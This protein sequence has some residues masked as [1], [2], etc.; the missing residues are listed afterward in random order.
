MTEKFERYSDVLNRLASEAIE[1][2]PEQW[3]E[4]VL[5]ISCDGAGINY[6]LKNPNSDLRASISED[7]RSLCE[8]LYVVM[9]NAGEVWV[10]ANVKF[11][12]KEDAEWGFS[13]EFSYS[14][15]N[16]NQQSTTTQKTK[17]ANA[18]TTWQTKLTPPPKWA[19]SPEKLL[20]EFMRDY[21]V[22]NDQSHQ[23]SE[24][25]EFSES[26]M[27]SIEA[28]WKK[29]TDKYCR[30]GFQGEPI[31]F[32]SESL[33]DTSRETIIS[34][35]INANVAIAKTESKNSHIA[36]YSDNYEYALSYD[37][38]RWFLEQI[39]YVDDE[40]KYPAL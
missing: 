23:R 16:Q 28:S 39:Y 6:S 26:L 11:F 37:G 36:N 7:L 10:Q 4:G 35:K 31:A 17:S 34:V 5:S 38:R 9:R 14:D 8:E 1:C 19:S 33:H 2:S 24:R 29:L 20:L 25:E 3:R 27:K 30:D 22:W 32:G 12:Q 21:K 15:S 13:F 18:W 40:G